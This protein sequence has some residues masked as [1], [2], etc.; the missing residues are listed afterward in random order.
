MTTETACRPFG[1]VDT[2][3]FLQHPSPVAM[4]RR[5]A[6]IAAIVSIS[7]GSF[8]VCAGWHASAEARMACCVSGNSCPMHQS[9]S[10]LGGTIVELTQ[11]DADR[12]CAAGEGGGAGS[13]AASVAAPAGPVSHPVVIFEPPV[14]AL[15][16]AH[17]IAL[18]ESRH[19]PTHVLLSVF[20]I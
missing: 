20:Q 4:I 13:V 2:D 11:A 6:A 18:L 10:E 9:D 15:D 5:L 19:V 17:T 8:G 3:G 14:V 16:R 7:A 12:C 1:G